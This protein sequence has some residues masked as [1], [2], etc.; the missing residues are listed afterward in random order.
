MNYKIK[1]IRPDFISKARDMSLD[2]QN[3]PVERLIAEG[4]EP[5]RD[6]L[7]R[8]LPGEELI[9]ASYCPFSKPGPYKEFGPVFILACNTTEMPDFNRLPLPAGN[10]TDYFSEQ[11]VIRAYNQDEAIV[12]AELCSPTDAEI[13]IEQ[14]FNNPQVVFILMRFPTYGCYSLRLERC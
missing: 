14:Y 11:F 9:L 8:A 12:N 10:S 7:R 4:G 13:T 6:V 3:Q 2:D 5:C 1:S